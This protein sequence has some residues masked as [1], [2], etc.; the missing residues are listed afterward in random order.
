MSECKNE[1]WRDYQIH[2]VDGQSRVTNKAPIAYSKAIKNTG[3][4]KNFKT[5]KKNLNFGQ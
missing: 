2:F 3:K 5:S 4:L 1:N